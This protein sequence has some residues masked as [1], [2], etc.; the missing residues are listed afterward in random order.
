MRRVLVSCMTNKPLPEPPK[1][2]PE[3]IEA[4]KMAYEK[5]WGEKLTDTEAAVMARKIGMLYS[6]LAKVP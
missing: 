5:D 3:D 2:T 4:F 1:L 6:A